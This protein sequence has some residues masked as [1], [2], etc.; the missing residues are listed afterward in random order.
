MIT[1][2][3]ELENTR[4]KYSASCEYTL[5]S[6]TD[7]APALLIEL[8]PFQMT[9]EMNSTKT[10]LQQLLSER[11]LLLDGAMGTM[12]QARRLSDAEFRGER[13][14]D[15]PYD[16]AGNND[17]L[18]LTQPDI[19][20]KIHCAN[21]EAGADIIETNTFNSTRAAQAD[22]HL[23]HIAYELNLEAARIARSAADQYND[24]DSDKPRFV[25]G[26]LGPTSR[27]ASISPDV[28][29]PG[30]RNTSFDELVDDYYSSTEGLID[31]GA[32]I[33]MIETS[34]DTLNA[35]AA[36]LRYTNASPTGSLVCRS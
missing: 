15:F 28:N 12:I 36:V 6:L 31:G 5:G 30:F 2:R 23:E 20:R 29:D 25:A 14:A 26:I 35:K 32:D 24:L 21:L 22:Y 4:V 9:A 17:L 33:V 1:D 19:I 10:R 27:S 13:F 18:S 34:F 8:R 3:F 11:I 7:S 16:L